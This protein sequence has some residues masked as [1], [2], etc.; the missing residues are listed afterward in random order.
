MAK[1]TI[2]Q[3]SSG[4]QAGVEPEILTTVDCLIKDQPYQNPRHVQVRH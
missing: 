1:G 3:M 4:F 2:Y